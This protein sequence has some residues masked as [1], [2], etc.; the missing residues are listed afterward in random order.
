ML[1]RIRDGLQGQKWLAWVVLGA[2]GLTFV[3]WGGS[4]ALDFSGMTSRD[5]ATVDGQEIPAEEATRAWSEAQS[6]WAQ[7]LGTEMPEEQRNRIQDRILESL[8]VQKL[9]ETRMRDAHYRV[10]NAKVLSELQN[11]SAFQGVNGT[12]DPGVAR[13]ALAQAGITE[14]E[15][16]Q[17]MRESLL[18]NQLQQGLVDSNF[19]LPAEAQRLKNLENEEREV[20]YAELSAELLAGNE[21]VADSAVTEYYENNP[22]RFMTT[23]SVAL[24]YAELRLEELASLVTPTEADLRQLYDD[25]R[26]SYAL[27]ER[28]RARHILIP[29]DGDDDAAAL[30]QAETVLAEARAG[31]D[32][33]EL[34]RHYSKD[35]TAASGGELGFVQH[36]DFPGPF[37]DALFAMKVG[38]IQG[39]VKSQFGYHLIKLEE[40]QA[41]ESRPFEEVRAELD[42]QYRQGRAAEIFGDRQEQIAE[43]IE[44]GETDLGK[45]AEAHGL[46]RGSIAEF[47]RGGG[48]DP[49]GS[50]SDLQDAVFDD[51]TLN[52]GKI[53]GPVG[54]G[55]DRFVIVKVTAHRKP[56]VKPL[57]EVREQIVDLLRH[58][59]G[60]AAAR[61][62][63]E[64]LVKRV[65]AGETLE[66][67]ARSLKLNTE[68]ARFVSRGDPSMPAALRT[69]VFEAPRPAEQP[70]VRTASL[71][72]GSVAVFVVSR[73]R[74]GD[75]ASN[76][77]LARQQEMILSQRVGQG[78]VAAYVAE[79]RRKAKVVKNPKVFE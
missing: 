38:D 62:Q 28:R 40:I 3:F 70:V 74:A 4:G 52:Q 68:P 78:D 15:F 66:Q 24:D 61:S 2:V 41:G 13:S 60:V 71:D 20:Q 14:G 7:Q 43:Q 48:A 22:D 73:S 37:G 65:E 1:Q 57:A 55:E 51:A 45:L 12:Y 75:T 32:F 25:N 49:L 16:L 35:S 19:L 50:S 31:K 36:R 79:A 17:Q 21:P 9:L 54:L 11:Y 47:L 10:S 69:A 27:D 59:R 58:E 6:R 63:A 53:A 76:P 46:S 39:P 33:G 26:A 29:T 30:K 72:D 5:A 34:A 77:Q 56:S 67:V 44:R 42:S 8:V 64:A 18:L 23:E